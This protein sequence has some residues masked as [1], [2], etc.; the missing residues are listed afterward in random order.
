MS[1]AIPPAEPCT[2]EGVCRVAQCP[3]GQSDSALG[4][5]WPFSASERPETLHLCNHPCA[6][7]NFVHCSFVPCLVSLE[8]IRVLE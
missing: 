7:T 8:V 5:G 1:G 2:A 4:V 3:R 6:C